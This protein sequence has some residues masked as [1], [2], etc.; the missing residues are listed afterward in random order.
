MFF[1][2]SEPPAFE[3][4]TCVFSSASREE[5]LLVKAAL[6]AADIPATVRSTK[7]SSFS[8]FTAAMGEVAVYVPEDQAEAANT[9]LN[10]DFGDQA[11]QEAS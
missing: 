5:A 6:D 4:W 3:G 2:P 1:Q 9:L 7:D 8:L 11:D 10:S